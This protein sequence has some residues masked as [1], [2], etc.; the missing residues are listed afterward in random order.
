ML[1]GQAVL[2]GRQEFALPLEIGLQFLLIGEA[3]PPVCQR[4]H[5]SGHGVWVSIPFSSGSGAA[6]QDHDGV[7]GDAETFQSPSS[8]GSGAAQLLNPAYIAMWFGKFPSP[9]RRG[10]GAARLSSC[11]NCRTASP[12]SFN[13]LLVGEAAP[14]RRRLQTGNRAN[15]SFNPLLV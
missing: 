15:N 8:R 4:A 14:P 6:A 7:H 12:I 5:D 10:S 11:A 1:I 13:P 2:P 9:S 3:A